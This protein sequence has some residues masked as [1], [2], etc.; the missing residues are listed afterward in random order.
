M[1]HLTIMG[2]LGS[3]PEVRFTSSGLKVTTFRV[4]DNQKRGGKEETLWWRVTIWG[5]QFDK[6]MPY[7]KKG[8]SIIVMGEMGKPEIYNDREGHPQISLN[9]T[10]YHISFSP[11]GRT[12]PQDET[13]NPLAEQ[14]KMGSGSNSFGGDRGDKGGREDQMKQMMHGQADAELEAAFADDEIPF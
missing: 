8:G 1:N 6:L 4:A 11:F 5:E 7:F 13:K 10:A 14:R 3:D 9:I 2:N 12:N